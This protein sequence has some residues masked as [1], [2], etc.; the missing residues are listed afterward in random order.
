MLREKENKLREEKNKLNDILLEK[1]KQRTQGVVTFEELLNYSL[2]KLENFQSCTDNKTGTVPTYPR[3]C[4]HTFEEWDSFSKEV[5]DFCESS[6]I[7]DLLSANTDA[8]FTINKQA[9]RNELDVHGRILNNYG[10]PLVAL[11]KV[12]EIS[13]Q[14]ERP[15]GDNQVLFDPDIVWKIGGEQIS[16][17]GL[18]VEA[19]PWW[20]FEIFDNVVDQY[21][22]DTENNPTAPD[23]KLVKAL[24]QIYGYMSYN[25]MRYGI[26][27]TYNCTYFLRRKGGSTLCI[28]KPNL[29]GPGILKCWLYVLFQAY[30]EGFYSSPTG[31]PFQ[32]DNQSLVPIVYQKGP[33]Y[34]EKK[35]HKYNLIP[36]KASQIMLADLLER[37]RGAISK[38]S[39]GSVISGSIANR[40]NIKFKIFDSFN[41][42]DALETCHQ[43]IMIYIALESLQG[44]VIPMF[45][46][47]F[48]LH[49]FLILALEDCGNPVTE[50]EYQSLKSK[51]EIALNEIEKARVK[52]NDLECRDGIYPNILVK[53]GNIRIIDFHIS[54]STETIKESEERSKIPTERERV[55]KNK[56]MKLK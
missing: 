47:F 39:C 3:D 55:S 38:G 26:L 4:G 56:K 13:S 51:I 29:I 46:G 22:E 20:S 48:N 36:I 6:I 25:Y 7:T 42:P 30:Q 45:Y 14:F 24:Q 53:N 2:P 8:K 34:S 27:T 28:S 1:E 41:T 50:A 9:C 43:E 18:V 12:L 40:E 32:L 31:N 15:G 17:L 5:D 54:E 52:H 49:G 33:M 35:N 23:S 19:K 10:L 16:D 37:K 21:K 11:L 44:S